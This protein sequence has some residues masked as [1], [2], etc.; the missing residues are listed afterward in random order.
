MPDEIGL[1]ATAEAGDILYALVDKHESVLD[2][3]GYCPADD[4][5]PRESLISALRF[6]CIYV[7]G[8]DGVVSEE[9]AVAIESIF[10]QDSE[11][12]ID[13]ENTR[14][15]LARDAKSIHA[16]LRLLEEIVG[17]HARD[18]VRNR[19]IPYQAE[20]D[21]LI[22]AVAVICQTVLAADDADEKEIRKLAYVVSR[23][24]R[25]AVEVQGEL[26]TEQGPPRASASVPAETTQKETGDGNGSVQ[27]T[28]GELH[29]LVG[30]E[31]VK[32]EVETLANLARV[33]ALRK[34]RGLPVPDMSFHLVFLGNPGTG[35][36]TVARI[37]AKLY[38][39]LGLLPSGNLIEVDRSGLVGSYVGQTAAKVQDVISKALGGV[40]FIDEAYALASKGDSDFGAEA[41]E[42]LLKAME[43]NRKNLIVIAAGYSEEMKEFLA[44]NPGLR[45]RLSRDLLFADYTAEQLVEIFD[46]M[47]EASDYSVAADAEETLVTLL[48]RKWEDRASNFAN[49]REV[50]NFFERVISEQANRIGRSGAFDE[51]NLSLLTKEDLLAAEQR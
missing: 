25:H 23:L 43:D 17:V 41:I 50:R 38:G 33:F 37:I 30:L 9:E 20:N 42:T 34:A 45:S 15:A 18:G 29:R 21:E 46:R 51:A 32:Q 22:N 7:A 14:Q 13:Y 5:D 1:S 19:H 28:L 49:A 6:I 8:A 26:E 39:Q 44:S 16:M 11:N 36:T 4:E 40:L 3:I 35:K 47:A 10:W 48:R 31:S 27:E 24:R 2:R 12:Y